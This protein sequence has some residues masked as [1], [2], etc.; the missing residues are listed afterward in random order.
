[1]PVD[2]KTILL[3]ESEPPASTA[4][5]DA[6]KRGGY[7]V[8]A[9][10]TGADAVA[11]VGGGRAIDLVLMDIDPGGGTDAAKCAEKIL[12]A[13][14]IPILFLYRPGESASIGETSRISSYGYVAKNSGDAALHASIN[15]A[16]RL[17]EAG[18]SAP[19]ADPHRQVRRGPSDPR[20][21]ETGKDDS[22]AVDH[23][24]RPF[25]T[26][27]EKYTSD[28]EFL[29]RTAIEF[30][31]LPPG[32]N[33]YEYIANCLHRMLPGFRII[34]TEIDDT[35]STA[36]IRAVDGLGGVLSA[37][38]KI[39][40]RNPVGLVTTVPPEA[41]S[42]FTGERIGTGPKGIYELAGGALP[43]AVSS[44]LDALLNIGTIYGMG[45]YRRNVLLG[46]VVLISPKGAEIEDR[47]IVEAFI[48][49][50]SVALQKNRFEEALAKSVEEKA[51]LLRELQHRVKNSLSIITGLIALEAVRYEDRNLR[52]VLTNIRDRV[53]SLSNLYD[54]L[55]SSNQVRE[56]RLD[57]YLAQIS[58]NLM[59]SYGTDRQQIDLHLDSEEITME[60]KQ[61][62]AV[63]LI[64]NELFTN[65]LKY[66]FPGNRKGEIRIVLKKIKKEA[67]LEIGDNGAGM[68]PDFDPDR[69]P[70]VGM[71]LVRMLLVQLKGKIEMIKR[72]GT[73]FR[74][75]FPI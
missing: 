18:A 69:S 28:L 7:G 35:A 55:F 19:S 67:V 9:A 46:T 68:P 41:K 12:G 13:R 75:T 47:S 70:G 58:G 51:S 14:G 24:I 73:M 71:E 3:V 50:A 43:K 59:V 5:A 29:S 61:A 48:K 20:S 54:L 8:I 53:S 39:L 16:L 17:H 64:V 27:L 37:G 44:A 45:F 62:L 65:S 52:N 23:P 63:G 60:A 21:F 74:L 34:V 36:T 66:A 40:G 49:Q 6:L 31:D 72:K 4:L 1:M 15:A 10:A 2:V 38:M 57:R 32:K 26:R 22:A 25:P 30:I 56:I 42:D 11:A 33:I